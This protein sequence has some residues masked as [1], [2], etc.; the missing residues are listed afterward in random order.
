[1]PKKSKESV[2]KVE[3]AQITKLS[4]TGYE[5]RVL[6]LVEKGLTSEKI[7][8]SLRHENIHPAEYEKKISKILKD[9]GAYES[10]DLRNMDEK[11]RRIEAHIEKNKQDKKA[12]R[13]KTRIFA[14]LRRLKKYH[15]MPVK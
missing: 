10:H 12:I 1:M 3:K 15:G 7:G 2:E 6:D 14:E 4:Q 9:K 5:K 13:E 8:E 11:L